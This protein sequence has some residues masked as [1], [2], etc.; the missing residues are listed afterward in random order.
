MNWI[1]G[2]DRQQAHLLPEQVE[3]YVSENNPVRLL[4]AFVEGQDLKA[5]GFIFP[6]E[7]TEGRGR[8]AYRP[9]DLL[10]LYL[11]G[12]LHQIRSSRRLEEECGR[13]LEMMWLMGK[14]EP[15]FKTIADFR[16]D[17]CAAF[18]EVVRQFNKI[19]QDLGLFGKELL[20][21]DG[22]KIK[23]QNAKDQNWSQSKLEKQLKRSEEKL[24]EYM[25]ALEQADAQE[26]LVS[27]SPTAQELKDKILKLK[28]RQTKVGQRLE[29]LQQSGESQ[30]S[31]TD[32]DSRGMKGN[33]GHLVG[34]NVQGAVDSKHHLLAVLEATNSVADQGQL[35][36]VAQATKEALQIEKAE[37][38]ADGGYYKNQDIKACQ[39]MGLEPY[40]PEV[41]NSPSERAGLYGK[42]DFRY[43]AIT[44]T[45]WCPTGEQLKLRR[46]TRD[47]GNILLNYDN[48]GA[49]AK[50]PL[51]HKCT[52]S[53]YRTVTRWEHEEHIQRMKRAMAAAPE[54]IKL[55]K[56]LIEHPWGTIKW[57]LP[58]GFL[59]RGLKK[60]AAEV[61]LV[62]W[63]YNFKRALAVVGLKRLLEVVKVGLKQSVCA[64]TG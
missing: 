14:L 22:T 19:C 8:P 17:N 35:A 29:K 45:H 50:C 7:N 42:E 25:Q 20:A 10:K 54:K 56:T 63:A 18:K 33:S 27:K 61:S 37:V 9:A 24:E 5:A 48:P 52:T 31:A 12:Y 16:K 13:N 30:L 4:E 2:W 41:E 38:L 39:D 32:P 55:R 21:I 60:V 43:D 46:K 44:D 23:G 28:E 15:D 1:K 3:E 34:Y 59:L 58:G 26:A 49:C 51:K 36:T 62:H 47:K 57:L 53:K 6:K 64:C 11:Y 40:V